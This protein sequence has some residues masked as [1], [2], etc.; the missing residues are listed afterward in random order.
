MGNPTASR[1]K[2][3]VRAE[4]PV[5]VGVEVIELP[6]STASAA[7][8]RVTLFKIDGREYSVP[9]SPR[10][11]IG[12][13]Y[14]RNLRRQG[15]DHATAALLEELLGVDGL[16]ALCD[17]DDLTQDQFK[18]I[19]AGAQKLVMGALEDEGNSNGSDR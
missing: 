3:S 4:S 8:D 9:A 12:I 5:D 1:R 13:R 10:A 11:V 17:Y 16:D 7:T 6:A 14:L 15:Q 2:P 18:S 19:M